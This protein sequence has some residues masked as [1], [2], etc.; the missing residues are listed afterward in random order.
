MPTTE[1]IQQAIQTVI[2]PLTGQALAGPKNTKNLSVHGGDVSFEVELGYHAKSR[3]DGLRQQ[4]IAAVRAVSGVQNV[5]VHIT[6]QVVAHA[7]QRGVALMPHEFIHP[8]RIAEKVAVIV[9][10]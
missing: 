5:S 6:S 4:L 10:K 8:A 9:V 7:A 3:I 2:D 1:Q